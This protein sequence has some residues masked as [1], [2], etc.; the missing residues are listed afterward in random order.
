[1]SKVTQSCEVDFESTSHA[2]DDEYRGRLELT[3]PWRW[4]ASYIPVFG[5]SYGKIYE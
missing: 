2:N 4:S 3:A 1:M 5:K